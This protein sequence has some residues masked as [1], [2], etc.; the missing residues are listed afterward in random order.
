M[1][2]WL[3]LFRI[4]PRREGGRSAGIDQGAAPLAAV[5]GCPALF[6]FN[7]IEIPMSQSL[8]LETLR[9]I[10]CPQFPLADGQMAMA[11]SEVLSLAPHKHE[12]LMCARC[13]EQ[14]HTGWRPERQRRPFPPFEALVPALSAS[15]P[16]EAV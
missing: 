4:I 8:D 5:E 10:A 15:P 9:A 12:V 6:R 14:Q 7:H 3:P 16:F 11:A 1:C 13:H 2:H